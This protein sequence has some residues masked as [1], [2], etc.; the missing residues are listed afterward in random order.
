MMKRIITAAVMLVLLAVFSGCGSSAQVT[1]P[2]EPKISD[3]DTIECAVFLDGSMSMQGFVNF[4]VVTEYV[5]AI[6]N[7][8]QALTLGWKNENISWYRFGDRVQRID[9]RD[10]LVFART[11]FYG[12]LLTQLD[13]IVNATNTE[14]LNV[15]VSDF[16]QT[17]QDFQKLVTALKADCL[18]NGKGAALIGVKSRFKGYVYDIGLNNEQFYYASGDDKN[19]FRPFYMLVLG[20]QRAVERFCRHY[21]QALADNIDRRI[22]CW[23]DDLGAGRLEAEPVDYKKLT[24]IKTY[25]AVDD[26]L[27][28]NADIP[29]YELRERGGSVYLLYRL[30]EGQVWSQKLQTRYQCAQWHEQ[31]REFKKMMPELIAGTET[32]TRGNGISVRLD[33][34]PEVLTSGGIYR[35]G[36]FVQPEND[37]YRQMQ[38]MK[39]EGWNME[40]SFEVDSKGVFQVDTTLDIKKFV[41]GLSDVAYVNLH[42]H[43]QE[44]YVYCRY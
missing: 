23:T 37:S 44:A 11:G 35:L 13:R 9:E 31:Q 15:I 22:I 10:R 25:A 27:T 5:D 26:I 19:Q 24:G 30:P 41:R 12:D 4:P 18:S 33:L 21:E 1:P 2:P 38:A 7:I 16:L 34:Q 32:E 6:N 20:D 36:L 28:M 14:Q 43:Y 42:P 39:L 3:H 17:D 40:D 29:Q 8:E